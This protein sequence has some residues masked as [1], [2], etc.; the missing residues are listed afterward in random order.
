MNIVSIIIPVYNVAQYVETC[1]NSLY[2]QGLNENQFEIILINDGSTDDTLQIITQ[3]QKKHT[4]IIII[5]QENQG[6]SIARNRG[7]KEATGKYI[8]FVDSDDLL[9]SGALAYL[10]NYAEQYSTDIIEGKYIELDTAYVEK[11]KYVD[12]SL[13]DLSHMNFQVKNGEQALIENFS[14]FE[15]HVMVYLYNRKYLIDNNLYFIPNEY[16]EDVPYCINIILRAKRFLSLPAIFYIYRRNN[17]SITSNITVSKLFSMNNILHYLFI[18]QNNNQISQPV[19]QQIRSSIFRC[20]SLSIWYLSHQKILYRHRKEIIN[21]LS[22][23]IPQL[24]LNKSIKEYI[25]STL[26]RFKLLA[27]YISIKYLFAYKKN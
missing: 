20:I 10:I 26:F 7:I 24:T 27:V 18:Q 6:P 14:P 9:I 3:I 4:N 21:D 5:T 12:I 19:K 25:I 15:I 2:Q 16:F 13:P 23:K 11:K 17:G 8:S 1:I 22:T